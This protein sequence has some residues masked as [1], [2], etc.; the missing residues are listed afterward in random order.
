MN[1][2][3]SLN[4]PFGARC[5]LT[6]SLSTLI[7][8]PISSFNAPFG[9]RCFL[10]PTSLLCAAP[11]RASLNAPFGARCFLTMD[12][13]NVSARVAHVVLMHLLALGAF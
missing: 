6:T 13:E 10:T 3:A 2:A 12:T 9:A 1:P 8:S 5:F 11:R 4:A 7:G